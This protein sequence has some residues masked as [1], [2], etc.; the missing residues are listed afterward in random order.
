MVHQFHH[1]DNASAT[2]IGV[3]AG[4]S[5]VWV[6]GKHYFAAFV[7]AVLT[8]GGYRLGTH[9]MSKVLPKTPPKVVITERRTDPEIKIEPPKAA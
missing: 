5:A 3:F 7:I 4:V 8:G 1:F 2:A 6:E 9:L